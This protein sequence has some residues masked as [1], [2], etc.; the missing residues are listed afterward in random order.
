MSSNTYYCGMPIK[1]ENVTE[2]LPVIKKEEYPYI[3]C[4]KTTVDKLLDGTGLESYYTF[5]SYTFAGGLY[6]EGRYSCKYIINN[7]GR[8][9]SFTAPVDFSSQISRDNM[10]TKYKSLERAY[11]SIKK[12]PDDARLITQLEHHVSSFIKKAIEDGI[13]EEAYKS[14]LAKLQNAVA[15]EEKF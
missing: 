3:P 2:E 6:A 4:L 15:E 1:P 12:N 5:V 10:Y 14:V 7:T 8:T 9:K 13:P 11:E